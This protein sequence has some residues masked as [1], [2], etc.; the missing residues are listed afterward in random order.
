M[1]GEKNQEATAELCTIGDQLN[2]ACLI[3][4]P[5]TCDLLSQARQVVDT[6]RF[7]NFCHSKDE[8]F[9]E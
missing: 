7:N 3:K 6:F 8:S 5:S 2:F 9:T 4:A 1:F